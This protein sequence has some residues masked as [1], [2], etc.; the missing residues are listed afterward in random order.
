MAE[1]LTFQVASI[2]AESSLVFDAGM[3]EVSKQKPPGF[4]TGMDMD[5]LPPISTHFTG[6][7]GQH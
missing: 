7:Q 4:P 1:K 5:S 2:A 6:E 3:E